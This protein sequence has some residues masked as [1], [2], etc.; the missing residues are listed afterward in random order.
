[1][2]HRGHL[3]RMSCPTFMM[4]EAEVTAAFAQPSIR[5]L[6]KRRGLCMLGTEFIRRYVVWERD[7]WPLCVEIC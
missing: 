5:E 2:N 4:T 6:K 3:Y 1:V 7:Y